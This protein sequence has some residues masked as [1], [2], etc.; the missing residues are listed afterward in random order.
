M[1]KYLGNHEQLRGNDFKSQF[2][3]IVGYPNLDIISNWPEYCGYVFG[4]SR[5]QWCECSTCGRIDIQFE[6][7]AERIKCGC[8][9]DGDK[10]YNRD[11]TRLIQAY[12]MAMAYRPDDKY[13]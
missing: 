10:G 4:D 11:S 2:V 9:K 5:Y 7:R 8:K 3:L 6:G 13:E 12:N 1:F